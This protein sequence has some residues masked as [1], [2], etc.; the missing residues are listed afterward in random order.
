MADAELFVEVRKFTPGILE[1]EAA[2]EGK[3]SAKQVHKEDR[4]KNQNRCSV[5]VVQDRFVAGHE[6]QLVEQ[7]E[8][9]AQQDNDGEQQG[10]GDHV[11]LPRPSTGLRDLLGCPPPAGALGEARRST[12]PSNSN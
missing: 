3:R 8:S 11:S 2:A 12:H 1:E 6:L 7:P 5:R 10:V 4:K 9:V